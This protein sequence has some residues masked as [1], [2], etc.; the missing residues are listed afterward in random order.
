[1][2]GRDDLGILLYSLSQGGNV[3]KRKPKENNK[4]K[5]TTTE[6]H[7]LREMLEIKV[8]F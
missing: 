2:T 5:Y 6:K 4:T 1:M 7:L 3:E 8:G